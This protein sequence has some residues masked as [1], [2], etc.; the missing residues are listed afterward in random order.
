MTALDY[1]A[2]TGVVRI[3]TP[4]RAG[5]EV[6]TPIWAVVAAGVPYVRSGYGPD[7]KWYRRATRAGQ[8]TFVDADHRYQA[9]V[10]PITD[11]STLDA[12]DQAYRE[13][14]AGQPGTSEM[15]ATTARDC[16]LR[17]NL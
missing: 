9:T 4:L 8:V 13:K 17:V 7:S 11:T 14:Y 16:T 1:L 6:V 5:G 12:V 10:S 15:I 3:A 2:N